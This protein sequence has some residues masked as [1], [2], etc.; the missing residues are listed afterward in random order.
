MA[1]IEWPRER[2][3]FVL[4][5]V[6]RGF[7]ITNVDRACESHVEMRN[8]NSIVA[9]RESVMC[10]IEKEIQLGRY[11]VCEAGERPAIVSALGAL[12]KAGGR[13]RL[14][15]DCSRPDESSVNAR[16]R[17]RA[18]LRFTCADNF[19][20]RLRPGQ[21]MTKVDLSEA[22][23]A[24]GIH[25]DDFRYTGLR[26]QL[27]GSDHSAYMFDTRLPFGAA[28]SVECFHRLSECVRLMMVRRGFLNTEAFLD[29]FA[30][31]GSLEECENFFD[32]LTALLNR[33]GFTVNWKKSQRA[34]RQMTFLGVEFDT[35][36]G[37]KR[38]PEE[39]A[40]ELMQLLGAEMAKTRTSWRALQRVIGKLGWASQVIYRGR[41]MLKD[42]IVRGNSF[43]RGQRTAMDAT[44][45]GHLRW[46]SAAL[47]SGRCRQLWPQFRDRV[48][49]ESDA[50]LLGGAAVLRDGGGVRDWCYAHWQLDAGGEF[51]DAPINYKEVVAPL[52]AVM[53]W[54]QQLAGCHVT[55]YCDNMAACHIINKGVS[56][57]PAVQ[58]L[59]QSVAL[60]CMMSGME[61]SAF[62]VP[63]EFQ[64]FADAASRIHERGQLLNFLL[65]CYG[66]VH[67]R[68]LQSLHQHA[69]C[70]ASA[71]FLSLQAA[72]PS[73]TL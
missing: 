70:S 27:P 59:L 52:M 37:V 55:V 9:Y 45:R 13:I 42:V 21:F 4:D 65:R 58:R 22:Y 69:F 20:K 24:C 34:S 30:F 25:P 64:I 11:R 36:R 72:T 32:Q 33:L 8:Y 6:A 1:Q 56:R 38:L 18:K 40:T 31:C 2:K 51:R 68:V 15:H 28:A 5:G 50:C 57:C 73:Q 48:V 10:Q 26:V 3:E 66:C 67:W 19:A 49:V 41:S 35:E 12:P 44:L 7:R 23:R 62:H 14:I 46:W 71:S 29:D 17:A 43:R 53:R 61:I 16:F 60:L 39:K 54:R 63:G 47:R